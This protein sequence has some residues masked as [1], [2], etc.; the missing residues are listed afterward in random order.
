M[1]T[2][3][4]IECADGSCEILISPM[5]NP[6]PIKLAVRTRATRRRVV[7][8]D[9]HK[10]NSTRILELAAER[11]RTR[12]VDVEIVLKAD[13]SMPLPD[14]LLDA[15]AAERGLLLSAVND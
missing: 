15:F 10:P 7:F 5:P 9:S 1:S 6:A 2:R 13:P 11:L 4:T 12:G 3:E 8:I 14:S